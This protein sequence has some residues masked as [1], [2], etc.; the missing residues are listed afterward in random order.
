MGVHLVSRCIV[1]TNA[2]QI[3]RPEKR[4]SLNETEIEIR[5]LSR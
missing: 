3:V 2:F 4:Y 1:L 5:L